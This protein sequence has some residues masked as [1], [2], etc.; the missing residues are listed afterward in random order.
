MRNSGRS[1]SISKINFEVKESFTIDDVLYL[2]THKKKVDKI[3]D[4]LKAYHYFSR[5]NKREMS[6]TKFRQ[7]NKGDSHLLPI[8]TEIRLAG[9]DS[10][11]LP[12]RLPAKSDAV[13]LALCLRKY[14]QMAKG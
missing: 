6:Y 10:L 14:Y 8:M 7:K 11:W 2:F 4:F 13:Y 5:G 9:E 3:Y 1:G 12:D